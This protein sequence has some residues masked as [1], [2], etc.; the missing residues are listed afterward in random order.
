MTTVVDCVRVLAHR[1]P[2]LCSITVHHSFIIAWFCGNA[3]TR[4]RARANYT[5]ATA[6]VHTQ[7][8][9]TPDPRH[10]ATALA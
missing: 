5:I 10:H 9:D 1:A 7:Y 8:A 3:N 2:L 4:A 6:T